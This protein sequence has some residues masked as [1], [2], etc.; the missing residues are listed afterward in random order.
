ML[1]RPNASRATNAERIT[2]RAM[3]SMCEPNHG[4]LE[5]PNWTT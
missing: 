3:L 5:T 2:V 1:V 4:I